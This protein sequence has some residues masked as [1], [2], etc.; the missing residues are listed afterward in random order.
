MTS[1]TQSPSTG[2]KGKYTVRFGYAAAEIG[3]T[4]SFYMISSYLAIF[5]TDCVGLSPMIVS[6]LMLVVR[7]I[8]AVAAPIT[9]G[10]NIH[11]GA[12]VRF[13]N[14][15]HLHKAEKRRCEL[16]SS[17]GDNSIISTETLAA[18]RAALP[19]RFKLRLSSDG[20]VLSFT[21]EGNGL[22]LIIR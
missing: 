19:E 17:T 12:T 14:V 21:A 15:E 18:W 6:G 8:E 13:E 4:L 10:I 11:E 7:I 2:S 5:Y 9:G 3:T 16:V 20:K 1:T 22:M